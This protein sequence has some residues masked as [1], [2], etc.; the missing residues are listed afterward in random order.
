[1][2]TKL[3]F[4]LNSRAEFRDFRAPPGLTNLQRAARWFFRNAAPRTRPAG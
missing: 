4:V 1:M 3:E 2:L